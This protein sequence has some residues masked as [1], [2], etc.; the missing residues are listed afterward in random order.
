MESSGEEGIEYSDSDVDVPYEPVDGVYMVDLTFEGGSGKSE[1]LSPALISVSGNTVTATLQWDSPNYDYMIV[2]GETYLPLN[3]EGNSVFEI[4]VLW[5]D[6][7]ITVIGDTIAMSRPHE[8]EYTIIFHSS[9]F[10]EVK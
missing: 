7:P 1:I 3:T 10:E 5:F 4:P 9:S 6:E 2:D 8:I